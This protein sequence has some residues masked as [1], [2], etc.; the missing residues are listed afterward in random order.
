MPRRQFIADLTKSQAGVLPLGIASLR[1]GDDDGE[2]HFC[3][4]A[5]SASAISPGETVQITACVSDLSDYPQ[6]HSYLLYADDAAPA[7]ISSALQN[8]RGTSGKTVFELVDI[9]AANLLR[10]YAVDAQAGEADSMHNNDDSMS[11]A[12]SSDNELD[13]DVLDAFDGAD[14]LGTFN[15]GPRAGYVENV[16]PAFCARL[17]NDIRTV[18]AAGFRV[19]IL[20]NQIIHG[21]A[22]YI[23]VSIRVAKLK[24]SPEA[25]RA[26]QIEPNE[27]IIMI[28]QYPSG[29]RNAEELL[30]ISAWSLKNF[31]GFRVVAGAHYK[32]TLQDAI[33]AFSTAEN[34]GTIQAE[35]LTASKSAIRDVFISKPL[36]RLLETSL[37]SIL[38]YRAYALSW[39]GAEAWCIDL[40]AGLTPKEPGRIPTKYFEPEI[41]HREIPA[42]LQADHFTDRSTDL[43]FPLL[44]MQ[45]ML[46]HF[47]RCTEFC[48]VCHR[49][50][51][52]DVGAIK[53][54]VCDRNLCL[55]QYMT[56][57][58]GP[59]IEHEI[60]T[61][62]YVV[63]LLV[64]FCYASAESQTLKDPP[65]GLA[66]LVPPQTHGGRLPLSDSDIVH[67]GWNVFSATSRPPAASMASYNL[68]DEATDGALPKSSR[69]SYQTRYFPSI[70]VV[71]FDDKSIKPPLT[72]GT[73]V[74]MIISTEMK[75]EFYC[76]VR[77]VTYFPTIEFD[78][79]VELAVPQRVNTKGNTTAVSSL[80]SP[81]EATVGIP[82]VFSIC[83]EDFESLDKT[84]KLSAMCRMLDTLPSVQEMREHVSHGRELRHWPGKIMPTA[85][86]L[87]TW[88]IASNRACI[89]QVDSDYLSSDDES[90]ASPERVYG[91]PKFLQFRFAMGAPDK[92]QRF[93]DEV[94]RTQA[95]LGLRYPTMFAWH[96]SPLPNWHMIIRQGLHYNTVTHGR[97]YG[98]G[99]YHAKD[100]Q[101]S[102]GYSRVQ[103]KSWP[104]SALGM[105]CA[106]ALSE[107]VNAPEEFVSNNPYYVVQQLDWI[108]TRYLFVKP[109]GFS[110]SDSEIKPA[111]PHP[112]DPTRT[113]RGAQGESIVIPAS[114]IKS[115]KLGVAD[116][117]SEKL[118]NPCKKQKC[119]DIS[120][121]EGGSESDE[122]C[123][124]VQSAASE[125]EDLELLRG[126]EASES[127]DTRALSKLPGGM[128]TD[129]IAG[130][131]KFESLPLMAMPNY[132]STQT[133]RHLMKEIQVLTK[134]QKNAALVE[135]GWFIDFDK[136]DNIYQWIV[137]LHSFHVLESNDTKLPLVADMKAQN[138]KSV[139]LEIRFGGDFP[140]SPPYVRVIRPRFLTFNQ[141]GGGHIVQGGA[142][143]MELLTNTGWSSVSSLESVLLQIRMAMT[144]EPHARLD[145]SSRSGDYGA[146]EGAEGYLRACRT[147][148]WVVPPGFSEISRQSPVAREEQL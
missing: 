138:V 114:A 137:E 17:R 104:N 44:A 45:F 131:L 12:C 95:R 58:F 80:S 22:A 119:H 96:G 124:D 89:V 49:K 51:E 28:I 30:A 73:W 134:I 10:A 118:S 38:G 8:V 19:G 37:M 1:S 47:V 103:P 140:F 53:P 143:C 6:T 106:L 97:A 98:D 144:S 129:F 121:G 50:I 20:S 31:V 85:L 66:L 11:E 81:L 93:L 62:P 108:Q 116:T 100:A 148:G 109:A 84:A 139:V 130:S 128:E 87:L 141:G 126:D 48:L 9:V 107:I 86:V 59:N 39:N 13:D 24:I 5:G 76:R 41:V 101:T 14:S 110:G 77:H 75:K 102:L 32:P 83:H 82:A 16:G 146:A 120:T 56:L 125:E 68:S 63:D 40:D 72:V 136:I 113:P 35:A 65:E 135:L 147:H 21:S 71:R 91:M 88:I 46:R 60:I 142:M 55:Y 90:A 92:E 123:W 25:M 115:S 99:V 29:Y 23:T 33:N 133:S 74:L 57:G 34:K 3:F 54:Y 27:Y 111:Q 52:S 26:W 43:S 117:R 105:S 15:T 132:A 112:Q 145:K 79:P 61:Q 78:E 36:T 42:L 69:A 7:L 122:V 127:M 2:L 4:T 67:L 94:K 18:K 70:R 64:S